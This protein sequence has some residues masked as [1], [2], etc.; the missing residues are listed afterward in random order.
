MSDTQR[1]LE[2]ASVARACGPMETGVEAQD[3]LV[4]LTE[5]L[6]M[7]M[8]IENAL[9]FAGLLIEGAS[10]AVKQLAPPAL[11]PGTEWI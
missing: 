7:S 6:P 10:A 9:A 5:P 2:L 11:E 8:T 4:F 1:H 3:G